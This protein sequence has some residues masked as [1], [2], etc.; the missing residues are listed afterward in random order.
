M[1]GKGYQKAK[2]IRAK[3]FGDLMSDKLI[4]GQGIGKSLSATISEKTKASMTG[5]KEKVDPLNIA[6]F[7]T[8]G[9]SLGPALLGKILGRSKEDVKFFAGKTKKGKDTA[10]K[11]G[12]IGEG[13][14][15]A[16]ILY[17][18]ENLLKTSLE[19]DK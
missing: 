7:M 14:D 18:I 6:K 16:S 15:F 17:N 10:S 9:S 11:L 1:A 4:A 2:D 5:L 3:S 19:E 12:P 13:G 8:G